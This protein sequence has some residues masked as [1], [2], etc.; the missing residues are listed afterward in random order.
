[1][2][3]PPGSAFG[4]PLQGGAAGGP[5]Q[6]DPRRP[7][8][9]NP[10]GFGELGDGARG[11]EERSA[12][13]VVDDLPEKL[14]VFG[15][16][17][18]E[19]GQELVFVR[20]GAEAL[21]EVLKREFAVIL[22]DVNMPDI[23]G[24][25]TAT[26]IRRYKRSAHTPIIFVT[27]YAD[28]LQTER[29]YSLGAVDFI[30]SP[31]VPTVLRTKVRVFVELHTMR[32]RVKRQGEERA[33]RMA[34]EAGR[35]VAEQND[36]RSAFLSH[37]SRTLGDSLD[38]E[39]AEQGL[40]ELLLPRVAS[41]VL[42]LRCS[43][44]GRGIACGL[45]GSVATP[46]VRAARTGETDIGP[47]LRHALAEAHERG[48]RLALDA[49]ARAEL[50]RAVHPDGDGPAAA[51]ALALP[52]STPRRHLGVLFV[53]R[54]DEDPLVDEGPGWSVLDELAARAA[55]AFENALL[56]RSLQSE[57]AERVAAQTQLQQSNRRKDEFL[58]MLGHELRNPLAPIRNALELL[59][60]VAPPDPKLDWAVAVMDRQLRQMAR[61]I[62]ELLDVARISQGKISIAKEAVDLR[63]VIGASV[64]T[65]QPMIDAHR[66][67]LLLRVPEVPVW[68]QG[69]FAR[70]SQVVGNLLH[71]AAKYSGDGSQIQLELSADNGQAT[72]VVRD[73]GIGIDAALLP[74]IFEP[75]TQGQRSLDRSQG[76][77]G[78]GLTL[79]QRL[80]E[81]HGGS[82][83]ARSGGVN[84]GA[85]FRV[86]LPA[87]SVL[88][89]GVS[90]PAI[91]PPAAPPP[92]SGQRVLI[93]DDNR[94]AAD[95]IA[96]YLQLEGHEVKSVADA[97]QAL[98][99]VP[100]FAPQ[101]AV[102]DIGLPGMSGYELA[103]RLRAMA[104]TRDALIVAMT[105][106]GQRE[107][108]RLAEQAGFD[109]HF[110]KPTDPREVAEL[111]ARWAGARQ[112]A[113]A[114]APERSIA[115]A[116]LS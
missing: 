13:L 35:R 19:L 82:V 51:A 25:E 64:E 77:L 78:V 30:L 92:P 76:G 65:H 15:T 4:A 14:L 34:A 46:Q 106:Y 72:I 43:D 2:T 7:L 66:H 18:E 33:A 89:G 31:V 10:S 85:E 116:R 99:S 95:S 5:A 103:S 44:D 50:A 108:H 60:R 83:E 62:E 87:V 23:D 69:D 112:A 107:D 113:T 11:A 90:A 32:Q 97:A 58:A 49:G 63:A 8:E 37:A 59:R 42:W 101:V 75:F 12:I 27:S 109:H 48:Q 61:L 80:V 47:A 24:F 28:E 41:T 36:R 96:Q 115:G 3:L 39:L 17:L 91:E 105:G 84:Q 6:P 86:L 98:A 54:R 38:L 114:A 111:I 68:L 110:V 100:V 20:S 94:D 71:N 1:M 53:A 29:G 102:L 16:V 57:N 67:H 104:P 93:V 45:A 21:R 74:S 22:L 81:L 73:S 40:V 52:I 70:L 79:V 26:L 56:Y 55:I 88:P 9:A